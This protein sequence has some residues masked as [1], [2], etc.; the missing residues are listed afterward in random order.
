MAMTYGFIGLG[1]MG[2][3][4]AANLAKAGQPLVVFDKAGTAERAP[5]GA[6]QAPSAA[7]VAAAAACVFLSLPDGHAVEAVLGD[8]L[9]V[10]AR[11]C[12]E[13][14]DLST[15]GIAAAR[16]AAARCQGAGIAYLDAPVSGGRAGAVAGTIAIM[17]AGPA[18][19][20]AAHRPALAAM[21]RNIFHVGTAP[22]QG[23]ALKLL[24]NFLSATA[25][26]ATAEA[27]HFGRASG[28]AM[29]TI[30]DVVNVSTGRSFASEDK[31]V[32]RVLTGSFDS[33]FDTALMAKDMALYRE[34][35]RAAGA[36]GDIGA[37][38]ETLWRAA[39]AALPDSDHTRIFEFLRRQDGD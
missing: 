27:V 33:G 32:K 11:R 18:E 6:A 4:M 22:G 17:F 8:L 1:K 12:V 37:V 29:K 14:I 5:S 35:A 9:A 10:P 2:G 19:R 39:A 20:L 13:I 16:D 31:F 28:L 3:P 24:N 7:A 15:V 23:Q 25:T 36:V 38:V 34:A 26:A 21:A 30:L